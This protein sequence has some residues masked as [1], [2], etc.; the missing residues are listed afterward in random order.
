M[1]AVVREPEGEQDQE[2]THDEADD[3]ARPAHRLDDLLAREGEGADE[4]LDETHAAASTSLC[5]S[6]VPAVAG[7][8]RERRT[9]NEK[10]SSNEARSSRVALTSA[11]DAV[12][13]STI[14]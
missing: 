8:P 13:L 2:G 5:V 7:W 10:T 1:D 11:P 4:E 9:S 6:G 14:A 3:R 12:R